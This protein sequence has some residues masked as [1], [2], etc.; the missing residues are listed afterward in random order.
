MISLYSQQEF[1][2]AKGID[3][4]PC[5][6]IQCNTTF[7][8]QKKY[9]KSALKLRKDACNFCSHNC[10][11][12]HRVQTKNI[13]INCLNCDKES[14]KKISQYNKYKN[15]FC[16]SSCAAIYN[17]LHLT[18]KKIGYR[19]S[20]LELY[21]EEQLSLLF[22]NL[23]I[24]YN[25]TNTINSELDIYIPSLKL[26]FELNGIFHY[27]PIYGSE[28][29]SKIQNNDNRKFQACLEHNIELCIIDSSQQNYVTK[30]TNKPFLDIIVNIINQRTSVLTS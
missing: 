28:Q 4:L 2:L 10:Y 7:S 11:I 5:K 20:K 24:D 22:P 3:L 30:K 17:N 23:Y 26:A 15:N 9:I 13:L 6:C 25:K 14:K 12:E 19:R 21:L 18:R 16:S 1:D 27:E 8:K 29:L